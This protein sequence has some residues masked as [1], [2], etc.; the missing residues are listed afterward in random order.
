MLT[1]G[2]TLLDRIAALLEAGADASIE[3]SRYIA[4][5]VRAIMKFLGRAVTAVKDMTRAFLR[6]V[7]ELLFRAVVS[8]ARLALDR[9]L[10]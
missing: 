7:L 4:S 2:A 9:L 8:T 5:L 3:L 6:W 10:D 1:V